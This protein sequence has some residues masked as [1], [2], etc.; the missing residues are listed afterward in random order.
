MQGL[1]GSQGPTRAV[2]NGEFRISPAW[3]VNISMT[4]QQMLAQKCQVRSA[5]QR[6]YIPK[7]PNRALFARDQVARRR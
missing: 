7:W 6:T 2:I 4:A 1:A 5:R 3:I